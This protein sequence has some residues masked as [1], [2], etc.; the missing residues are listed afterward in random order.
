L[1][2]LETATRSDLFFVVMTLLVTLGIIGILILVGIEEILQELRQMK[3][4]LE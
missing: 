4:D 3:K 2:L 1:F